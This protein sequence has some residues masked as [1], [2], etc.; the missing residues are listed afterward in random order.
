MNLE[1]WFVYKGSEPINCFWERS[2]FEQSINHHENFN[3]KSWKIFYFI[4]KIEKVKV[5]E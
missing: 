2:G 4:G 3:T 5:K 1:D